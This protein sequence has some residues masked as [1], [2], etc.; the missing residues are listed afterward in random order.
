[1]S[2][3]SILA[4]ARAA[5]EARFT[6]TLAIGAFK[7]TTDPVT[8]KLVRTL[9]TASYEGP[10]QIVYPSLTVADRDGA[11]QVAVEQSPLVKLPSGTVVPVGDEV[12]VVN[13]AADAS[14]VGRRYKINGRSQAGQTS[15]ARFPLEEL[16]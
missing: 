8:L 4:R 16:S 15:A 3:E 12:S 14:L 1:M 7:K 2:V 13:S 9:V 5:T 11:S 6:E 10:G